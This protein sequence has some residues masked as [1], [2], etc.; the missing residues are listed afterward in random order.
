MN[1]TTS[2]RFLQ[3]AVLAS[4]I[5]L[6]IAPLTHTMALRNVAQYVAFF[7]TVFLWWQAGKP[8][9]PLWQPLVIWGA[10]ACLSLAWSIDPALSRSAIW[11]QWLRPVVA[12]WVF[13]HLAMNYGQPWPWLWASCLSLL[14]LSVGGFIS[15]IGQPVWHEIW[16]I[17]ALADYTGTVAFALPLT[18][19]LLFQAAWRSR[20]P[21]TLLPPL[22]ILPVALSMGG[23]MAASRAFWVVPVA[24][25]SLGIVLHASFVSRISAKGI[26]RVGILLAVCMLV[27]LLSS[28]LGTTRGYF[29][30]YE[31]A[32]L[33][34]ESFLHML[35]NPWLGSGFGHEI[36]RAWHQTY[37]S[38][39]WI[40]HSHNLLLEYGGQLGIPGIAVILWV[41]WSLGHAFW[42]FLRHPDVNVQWLALLGTVL[43]A[44]AFLLNMPN[45][46]LVRHNAM[47]FFAH[48]GLLLGLLHRAVADSGL[49]TN[50]QTSAPENSVGSRAI[51]S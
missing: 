29:D 27:G 21:A 43:V 44:S 47:L 37:S 33:Y 41:F 51:P 39:T 4:A 34:R 17:P 36:N 20:I 11:T 46:Y 49:R 10:L 18:L 8:R 26:I 32:I 22:F 7:A 15:S 31:R 45:V 3:L 23:W 1:A 35:E 50:A 14:A 2:Q 42:Q 48:A 19:G 24:M 6:A 28:K 13:H 25:M 30:F 40:P 9:L 5:F 12:F 38:Q 16:F